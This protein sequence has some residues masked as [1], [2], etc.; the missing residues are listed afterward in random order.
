MFALHDRMVGLVSPLNVRSFSPICSFNLLLRK[1][2]R[3][4]RFGTVYVCNEKMET[5]LGLGQTSN[6]SCAEPNANELKQRIFF[7]FFL[8][9]VF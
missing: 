7:F 1:Q 2:R 4:L 8:F 6:F 9:F 3:T 5:A